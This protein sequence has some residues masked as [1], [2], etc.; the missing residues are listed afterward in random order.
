VLLH[1]NLGR[2]PLTEQAWD[3]ARAVNVGYASLELSLETGK[4]ER[5]G[6]IIPE[7][8]SLMVGSESALVVNNCASAVYLMLSALAGGRE[9]VVSRGEQ[10]QI[11]GGFRIPDML[12]LSGAR[13]AE[14]GTTNITTVDDYAEAIGPDTAMVL[15]VH[16]SN[17]RIR[18]FTRRPAIPALAAVIPD[19]VILA[20][21][22]GSGITGE[23]IGDEISVRRYL[24][25]GA[26][27]VC[28]SGDKVLG[29]PQAGIV[30]GKEE[31]LRVMA[32]HPLVRILR[33]GKTIRSLMEEHLIQ[34]LNGGPVRATGRSSEDIERQARTIHAEVAS[35]RCRVV[36]STYA[37]GGGSAPDQEFPSFSLELTADQKPEV[38]VAALRAWDPPIIAT[39][40]EG[41]VL[42]NLAAVD[43][44]E[45]PQIVGAVRSILGEH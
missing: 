15:V 45:S 26:D 41:R 10:I 2:S 8:L 4:R 29:G 38:L 12:R 19:G 16:P 30:V 42:L 6:G 7:L 40:S 18:G 14:V 22:Q 1:T 39:I 28:F 25:D 44:A 17:F 5:R 34:R 33:T 13:L 20:V 9:V 3:A 21:D 32:S 31:L 23:R 24:E 36:G 43:P 37:V 35:S 27:L 11:G